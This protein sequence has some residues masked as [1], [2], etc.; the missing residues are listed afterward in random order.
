[1]VGLLDLIKDKMANPV[2]D[3][4]SACDVLY[5]MATDALNAINSSI[6]SIIPP[7]QMD[8]RYP[9][10]EITTP[11]NDSFYWARVSSDVVIS[12]QATLA[13]DV[14][15]PGQKR[16][17]STGLLY[18]QLFCPK[19]DPKAVQNGMLFQ[20]QLLNALRAPTGDSNLWLRNQRPKPMTYNDGN[21]QFNV[22]ATFEFSEIV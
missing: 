20:T 12:G 4:S 18:I 2:I 1:L 19:S 17:D 11:A 16:Y 15:N 22:V 21:Y 10:T 13:T 7:A 14:N 9:G 3:Y 8:I 5:Q 6:T